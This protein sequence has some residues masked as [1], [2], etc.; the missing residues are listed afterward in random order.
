MK[1]L[2]DFGNTRLKWAVRDGENWTT[3]QIDDCDSGSLQ[4]AMDKRFATETIPGQ[5]WV[6]SVASEAATQALCEW[7]QRRW[8]LTPSTIQSSANGYGIVNAYKEPETL[9]S[10]RWAALVAVRHRFQT[11]ACIIDCGTA[12]TVDIL[13]KENGYRGGVI[14]P[15]L[16][17]L[18]SS[19]VSNTSRLN[20]SADEAINCLAD[21]TSAGI[22]SGT[23][24]GIVGAIEKIIECQQQGFAGTF[25]VY[26]TGGDGQVIGDRLG[27]PCNVV[28]DLVLQ[29]M[30]VISE[31]GS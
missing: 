22:L 12:T 26:L 14:F 6:S 9:G 30:D 18:R 27:L 21:T 13:D 3:G 5:A 10:D 11:P 28:E 16:A 20:I 1:V 23:L 17:L 4:P 29:G 15:G 8:Q 31:L 24:I 25:S 2:F 19:L 7:I